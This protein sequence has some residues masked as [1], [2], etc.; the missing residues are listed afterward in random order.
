MSIPRLQRHSRIF[1]RGRALAVKLL[2][3]LGE[4]VEE[5]LQALD[6][7]D[8]A[9]DLEVQ[10]VHAVADDEGSAQPLSSVSRSSSKMIITGGSSAGGPHEWYARWPESVGGRPRA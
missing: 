3:D 5:L 9:D 10:L 4:E 8:D 1:F 6:V 2:E 7:L